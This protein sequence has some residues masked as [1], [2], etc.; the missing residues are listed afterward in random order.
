MQNALYVASQQPGAEDDYKLAFYKSGWNE[1]SKQL[2]L[3]IKALINEKCLDA[4]GLREVFNPRKANQTLVPLDHI[5]RELNANAP[6]HPVW[7]GLTDDHYI[8]VWNTS[9]LYLQSHEYVSCEIDTQDRSMAQYFQFRNTEARNNRP[10]H[11]VHNHSLS[12]NRVPLTSLR[13]KEIFKKLWGH[14]MQ[15]HNEKDPKPLAVFGGDFDCSKAMWHCCLEH[16]ISCTH[17]NV[18]E[19]YGSVYMCYSSQRGDSFHNGDKALVFNPH[20]C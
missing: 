6:T 16:A 1:D 7:G 10:L 2:A 4:V 20:S 12:S 5:L 3:E 18:Y 11:V 15:N 19:M 13:R 9:R 14:V 17:D 8:F